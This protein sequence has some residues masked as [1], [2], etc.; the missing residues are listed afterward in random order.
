MLYITMPFI[1]AIVGWGTNV[2]A[3]KMTFYPLEPIGKPPFLG[4]QGIIPSKTAKMA[5]IAVDV[6]TTKLITVEEIFSQMD[7]HRVASE[8]E[9]PLIALIE[10]IIHDTMLTY[11]PV[12]WETLPRIAKEEI[13]RRSRKD[14]PKVC[15]E[16]MYDVKTRIEDLFDLRSMVIDALVRNKALMNDLFLKV[17]AAE[18]KFIERSGLYFGFIFGIVQMFIWLFWQKWWL[19]PLGGL[20]VGYATNDL[21][22]KLIFQPLLPK[23]IGP[24]TIQGLFIKRQN[25]VAAEYG[26]LVAAEILNPKNILDAILR[27]PGSD[28]LFRII[29]MHVKNSVDKHAGFAK[30]FVQFVIG[31]KDY[32]EMKH[33]VCDLLMAELPKTVKSVYGY[34]EEALNIENILRE[35]LQALPPSEFIGILRPAFQEDEW[36]LI[37]VGGVLGLLVGLF[38]LF[39]MFGGIK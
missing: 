3:L 1:S 12:L 23:R 31:T 26:K 13:F 7:P 14:L 2:V 21:A 16:I 10:P 4:W 32:I 39:V 25:E 19:L 29:Q 5:G 22:L 33:R 37:A 6:I 9:E 36:L 15:S 30:H 20:I 38:Q 18:F 11:S 8:L 35:K 28:D 34:A 24:F 17:G 27:G